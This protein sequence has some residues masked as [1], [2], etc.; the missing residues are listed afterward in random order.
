MLSASQLSI[1]IVSSFIEDL[2][3]SF[4]Q[5]NEIKQGNTLIEF[6]YLLF[7]SSIDLFHVKDFKRNL[8]DGNFIRKCI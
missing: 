7:S 8:A 4:Q 5:K 3:I 1:F 6:N 2:F